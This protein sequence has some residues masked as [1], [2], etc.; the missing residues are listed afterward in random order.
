MRPD[1][2]GTLVL[3]AEVL[4]IPVADLAPSARAHLQC[5][6]GD[7]AITRPRSRRPSSMLDASG[8][9]L[10][11]SFRT[12]STVVEAV[13]RYSQATGSDPRAV[14][15][16]AF[17][18]IERLV[19]GGILVVATDITS[20]HPV[21]ERVRRGDVFGE[22]SVIDRLKLMEDIEIFR[23]R[24]EAGALAVLKVAR[25]R[26][27]R[28]TRATLAREAA[29]LRRLGGRVAPELLAA[30][31]DDPRPWLVMSWCAGVPP[32][33]AID[34][35]RAGRSGSYRTA[36]ELCIRIADAYASLH[37]SGVLH[38]DVHDGNVLVGADGVVTVVDFGLAVVSDDS[39]IAP[40]PRGG[41][42]GVYDPLYADALRRSSTPPPLDSAA[43]QHSIAALLYRVVT[44]STHIE[45]SAYW[46]EALRQLAE[47][48]PLPF[49]ARGMPSWPELE[50][51]LR[52]ALSLNADDRFA[53]VV[54]LAAALRA[55]PPPRVGGPTV[56]KR[57]DRRR[58]IDA[59]LERIEPGGALYV[60]GLP[61]A[62]MCSVNNG[63]SGIAYALHRMAAAREDAGLLA[64]AEAWIARAHTWTQLPNA[65]YDGDGITEASVGSVAL[66]HSA[67]GLHCVETL[68]AL[69]QGDHRR[70]ERSSAEFVSA[71]QPESSRRDI[72]LGVAGLVVGAALM[73]D[74]S[75]AP[76]PELHRRGREIVQSLER[77]VTDLGPMD[78]DPRLNYLGIAHG[79]SGYLWVLM[80]W[81]R[82]FGSMPSW[83]EERLRELCAAATPR[84]RGLAWH[85]LANP[86]ALD[87]DVNPA[88]TWCNGAAG[89][90][91]TWLE[92]HAAFGD[93][94]YLDLAIAAAWNVWEDRRSSLS[95]ACCGLVGRAYSL[96]AVG[97]RT[98]DAAWRERAEQLADRALELVS[99][100]APDAHRLYKGA[101]GVALLLEELESAPDAA[102]MPLFESDA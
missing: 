40:A 54:E 35:H 28:A 36:L 55:V 53:S 33:R 102:R 89:H 74:A 64:S 81:H 88:P 56:T 30:E 34:P 84:G 12:P 92:A 6:V 58:F 52:R 17:P 4:L 77:Q 98:G 13:V 70:A 71:T 95:D 7:V 20:V 8:A 94:Q 26:H 63:A 37:A 59:L 83:I 62:P 18:V 75:P 50:A 41:V 97:R 47:E 5:A 68:I 72:T 48:L 67:T 2:T 42:P 78:S 39:S 73:L 43:E 23:V 27:A 85:S 38:G 24:S 14:L 32:T 96:L 61:R 46:D 9:E 45:L 90:V 91:H 21:E 82:S 51:V 25:E 69:A 57:V 60:N 101:L 100:H 11:A 16:R 87:L 49:E 19:V 65:W 79:W 86:G 93:E 44:G 29:V 76:G 22:F 66:Y 1:L 80:R 15:E 99:A 10:V 3:P 31:L